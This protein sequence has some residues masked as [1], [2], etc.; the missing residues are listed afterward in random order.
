[1]PVSV[2]YLPDLNIFDFALVG[3]LSDALV[4][5]KIVQA[6]HP[7]M[8]QR[9]DRIQ[10]FYG[11]RYVYHG[12]TFDHGD[13]NVNIA[14]A[15]D[16]LIAN[17]A[18]EVDPTDFYGMLLLEGELGEQELREEIRTKLDG[19]LSESYCEPTYCLSQIWTNEQHTER[20]TAETK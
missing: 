3:G 13:S 17:K 12:T 18:W 6:K 7:N 9:F 20:T 10:A 2:Y 1:M 15:I 14:K 5:D 11:D 19:A 8:S 4:N 16:L